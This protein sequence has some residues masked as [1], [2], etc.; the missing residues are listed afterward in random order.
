M[1]HSRNWDGYALYERR[2]AHQ[3]LHGRELQTTG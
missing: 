3:A 1:I 2:L